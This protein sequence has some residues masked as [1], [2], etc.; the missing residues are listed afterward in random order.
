[1]ARLKTKS[2]PGR[3]GNRVGHASANS[4]DARTEEDDSSSISRNLAQNNVEAEPPGM[5]RYRRL[6][7]ELKTSEFMVEMAAS[8]VEEVAD[9][10]KRHRSLLES[11]GGANTNQEVRELEA[12]T[13]RIL[14]TVERHMKQT[15]RSKDIASEIITKEILNGSG[16]LRLEESSHTTT[17][18]RKERP[19]VVEVGGIKLFPFLLLVLLIGTTALLANYLMGQ[20]GHHLGFIDNGHLH[21][22]YEK[23]ILKFYEKHNPGKL[24]DVPAILDKYNLGLDNNYPDLVERLEGK[25]GDKGY[26]S[27]L[28]REE[29]PMNMNLA[30]MFVG[31][32]DRYAPG[33]L[34]SFRDMIAYSLAFLYEEGYWLY[35][36]WV[37]LVETGASNFRYNMG[38]LYAR[39]SYLCL[40][41]A[42]NFR[43]NMGFFYGTLCDNLAFV[44]DMGVWLVGMGARNFRDNLGL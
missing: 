21:S 28:E 14:E 37:W 15:V 34:K 44:Y 35:R 33:F 11:N 13:S 9:L 17:K 3:I 31:Q 6:A 26:F 20:L 32:F 43:H 5:E 36:D 16:G 1:M 4:G 42:G 41:G 2:E 19:C 30:D 25:Y 27:K 22:P 7:A 39:G 12:Q 38:Y 23:R 24:K 8:L 29:A 40:V 10:R 18:R